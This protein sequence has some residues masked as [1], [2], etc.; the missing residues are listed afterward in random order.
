MWAWTVELPTLG[1]R[2]H[3]GD[4]LSSGEFILLDFVS[5][6][7]RFL[8][9]FMLF[10]LY[11][12]GERQ[13][14]V[15]SAEKRPV[16]LLPYMYIQE[17]KPLLAMAIFAA[18]AALPFV[19]AMLMGCRS[20]VSAFTLAY[21]GVLS[22][23]RWLELVSKSG[24]KGFDATAT[25]FA[26]YFSIPA[27]IHFEDGKIKGITERKWRIVDLAARMSFHALIMLVTLSL[28]KATGY[29]P[30]L[31]ALPSALPMHGLPGSIPAIYLQTI[32]VYGM[33]ATCM[34]HHRLIATLCGFE[35]LQGMNAPLVKSTSFR[36]F[37][38]RRWN[39]IIHNL[40]KRLIFAPLQHGGP[41]KKNLAGAAAFLVSGLFHEYMWLLLHVARPDGSRYVPGKVT[42]FFMVQFV[43]TAAQVL[44]KKTPLGLALGNLPAPCQTL[45]TTLCILPFGPLFLEGVFDMMFETTITLPSV[46]LMR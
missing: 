45:L 44:L 9:G 25:T 16:W 2:L 29:L 36:D 35:T 11:H 12:C 42:A 20:L 32:F 19:V 1:L 10:K 43:A 18:L 39:M 21:L 7:L 24:P 17:L 41:L 34:L 26:V 27:E 5:L 8:L 40:M 22:A 37:W 46:E 31:S 3:T 38:G 28:G 15:D 13:V 23:F 4:L 6:P 33:L 14:K 30:F